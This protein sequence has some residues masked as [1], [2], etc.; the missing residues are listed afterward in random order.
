[1]T[2]WSHSRPRGEFLLAP[3][4]KS[5]LGIIMSVQTSNTVLGGTNTD[6]LTH[7]DL[8]GSQLEVFGHLSE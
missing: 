4:D 2:K 7:Y 8:D 6:P 3:N 5:H 1:V